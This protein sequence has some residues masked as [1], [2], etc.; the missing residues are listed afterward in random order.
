[1]KETNRKISIKVVPGQLDATRQKEFYREIESC[2]DIDRPRVVLDCSRL[3]GL[4]C[5]STHL[6][7]CCLEEAMKRNGDVRLAAVKPEVVE[8]MKAS[9]L[10]LVFEV[11]ENTSEAAE[12]YRAPRLVRLPTG[13]SITSDEQMQVNAA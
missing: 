9:G 10:D 2:I 12:S 6:L 11:F 3:S 1:M 5:L 4:D 13:T 8:A 7:L